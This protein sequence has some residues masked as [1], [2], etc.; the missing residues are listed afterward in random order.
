[1]VAQNVVFFAISISRKTSPKIWSQK[2]DLSVF[3]LFTPAALVLPPERTL[4]EEDVATI[5]PVV[6]TKDQ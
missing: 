4:G 3:P 2:A 1:M 5:F 6:R